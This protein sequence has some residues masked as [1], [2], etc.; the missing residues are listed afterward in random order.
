MQRTCGKCGGFIAESGEDHDV[1]LGCEC[2]TLQEAPEAEDTD[3]EPEE[4]LF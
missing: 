2:S 3:E 1:F 4:C